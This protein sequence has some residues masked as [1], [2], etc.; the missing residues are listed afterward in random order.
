MTF[1]SSFVGR[2]REIWRE[3]IFNYL[4]EKSL[5]KSQWFYSWFP[6][7]LLQ[8]VMFTNMTCLKQLHLSPILYPKSV[9]LSLGMAR[10]LCKSQYA[11]KTQQEESHQAEPMQR[12]PKEWNE[13]GWDQ[14]FPGVPKGLGGRQCFSWGGQ[15]ARR[16]CGLS[17]AV[18]GELRVWGRAGEDPPNP[19]KID[20]LHFSLFT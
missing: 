9:S 8:A 18:L 16:R 19:F 3:K 17:Y 12:G 15:I 7:N 5:I 2:G 4:R 6:A 10:E 20:K 1:I 11:S 14:Q 13:G